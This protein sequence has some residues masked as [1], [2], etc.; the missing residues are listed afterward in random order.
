MLRVVLAVA[1]TATLLAVG[2][3]AV[4]T[5]RVQ[6]SDE[7]VA[8][9]LDRIDAAATT[10]RERNDRPPPGSAGP[11]RTVTLVLP[12]NAWSTAAVKHLTLD[13]RNA[14]AS[15]TPVR[16]RVSGGTQQTQRLHSTFETDGLLRIKSGGR[17]RLILQLQADGS[18]R[19]ERPDV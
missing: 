6:Y 1:M 7:R 5:A 16:W 13:A 8:A 10:L 14:T 11:R 17:H 9:E 4:E 2:L 15:H 18:V 19:I 3:P 12:E